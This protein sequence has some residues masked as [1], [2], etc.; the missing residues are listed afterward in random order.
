MNMNEEYEVRYRW[1]V[2]PD[3]LAAAVREVVVMVSDVAEKLG[4]EV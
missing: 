4:K 2:S 3:K 1:K